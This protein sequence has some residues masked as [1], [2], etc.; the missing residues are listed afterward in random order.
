MNWMPA[1]W[2]LPL[3][4]GRFIVCTLLLLGAQL[5]FG[6]WIQTNVGTP[7]IAKDIREI[8]YQLSRKNDF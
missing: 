1:W 4:V 5:A 2:G 3:T 7:D 8:K 6:M